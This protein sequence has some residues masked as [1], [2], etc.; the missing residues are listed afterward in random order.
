MATSEDGYGAIF[1]LLHWSTALLVAFQFAGGILDVEDEV[2]A[3]AG[4][5]VLALTLL[6]L[7]GRVVAGLPGW[8]P[9]LSTLE[10]HLME[11][12]EK[13]LYAMLF[14]KPITGLLLMGAD[15]EEI[16]LLGGYEFAVAWGDRYEDTFESLHLWSGVVLLIALAVHVGLVLRHQ[17]LLRDRLLHRML[18]FTRQ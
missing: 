14:A 16:E 18:P 1:K 15:D 11:V 7:A 17:L 9:G 13:V 5:L 2:H 12:Y 3:T 10:K 4:L 6:R 8:A